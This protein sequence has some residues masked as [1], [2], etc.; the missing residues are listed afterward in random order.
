MVKMADDGGATNVSTPSITWGHAGRI[1]NTQNSLSLSYSHATKK[2]DVD[3]IKSI[4]DALLSHVVIFDIEGSSWQPGLST[5]LQYSF[6]KDDAQPEDII[7]N[8]D[9]HVQIIK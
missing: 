4:G 3:T 1:G 5:S 2:F 6:Y 7:G 9:R 8:D